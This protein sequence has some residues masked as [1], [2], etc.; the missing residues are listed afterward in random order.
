MCVTDSSATAEFRE[1]T[2]YRQALKALARHE[3]DGSTPEEAALRVA[4]QVMDTSP[5][6]G[7][8]GRRLRSLR[9]SIE[10][11][12]GDILRKLDNLGDLCGWLITECF[13]DGDPSEL[14]LALCSLAFEA[15]RTLF[16]ITNQVRSAL[17]SD[18]F[19]YIR[20]LHE[21]F[22]KSRI[23]KKHTAGDPDLPGRYLLHITRNYAELYRSVSLLYRE[24]GNL[25]HTWKS[26][27]QSFE[28]R[29]WLDGKGDYGWAYP[30]VKGSGKRNSKRPTFQ[31]LRNACGDDSRFSDFYYS[32]STSKTHG[33]LVW[34]PVM[35]VP[36]AT[37][38]RIDSFS[39]G[40]I[41]LVMELTFPLVKDI[42]TSTRQS[43]SVPEHAAV[44]SVAEA[45]FDDISCSVRQVIAMDPMMHLGLDPTDPKGPDPA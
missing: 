20:T 34:N 12:W 11:D 45:I 13:R 33:D 21:L 29:F 4:R 30:S 32:M 7:T 6:D 5:E 14:R 38:F 39:I 17:A 44:M 35:V 2:L 43:C 36:D 41:G 26:N 40:D 1:V 24:G 19:G 37:T 3:R 15:N 28:S 8:D 31:N 18:T 22:V 16:A 42:I 23:L 25:E 10:K 27:L 9:R